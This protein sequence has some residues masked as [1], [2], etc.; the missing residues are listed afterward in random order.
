MGD[1]NV[2]QGRRFV[3]LRKAMLLDGLAM[4]LPVQLSSDL[5]YLTARFDKEGVG[6]IFKALPTLGR[7][8]DMALVT[9]HFNCPCGVRK[10]KNTSL[11]VFLYTVLSTVFSDS[12]QLRDRVSP[13]TIQW[14]RQF[15]LF[16]SKAEMPFKPEELRKF[17]D[18]FISGQSE[19]RAR[20]VPV[21]DPILNRCENIIKSIFSR[22]SLDT[23]DLL[24]KHGP[25]SVAESF[26]HDYKYDWDSWPKK[27]E[28]LF[29]YLQY[30][31][32]NMRMAIRSKPVRLLHPCNTRAVFVPKDFRGPRL[33]SVE[34]AA[35]QFLQQGMMRRLVT[36]IDGHLKASVRMADQNFNRVRASSAID[37]GYSTIDLSSASDTLSATLVWYLFRGVPHWRRAL[38]S[39]RSDNVVFSDRQCRL[40]AMSPMGSAICFPVQT[41]VFTVMAIACVQKAYGCSYVEAKRLVR[42]FGDDIIVPDGPSTDLLLSFLTSVGCKVNVR[43]TC[44]LTPFRESCGGEW[45]NDVP[46]DFVK[47][48]RYLYTAGELKLHPVFRSL[49]R[50]FFLQGYR[51]TSELLL[52]WTRDIFPTLTMLPSS[53][54]KEDELYCYSTSQSCKG[55]IYRCS[56]AYQRA[57]ARVPCVIS[58]RKEWKSGDEIGFRASLISHSYS[59]RFTTRD[60]NVRIVWSFIGDMPATSGNS[61]V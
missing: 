2:I 43:K 27:A 15:L 8:L 18:D 4:R 7:A 22:E 3:E 61:P 37:L 26:Q 31:H 38:F 56:V 25:G 49:Q 34:T 41:I 57:E 12:G 40:V 59:E 35:M 24:P 6:F 17:E 23:M 5:S 14:L 48:R 52:S 11:P 39:L 51:N 44:T 45:Y 32:V 9:G 50:K 1:H 55:V 13:V 47:N 36:V 53:D 10:K 42:V 54:K 58:K 20:P 46:V 29:P 19:L 33:I 21:S 28:R 16:D 60:S 30:G